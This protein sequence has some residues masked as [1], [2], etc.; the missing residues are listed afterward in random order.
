[1]D[2]LHVYPRMRRG[3]EGPLSLRSSC[4]PTPQSQNNLT[5]IYWPT[6]TPPHWPGFAPPLTNVR[7]CNVDDVLYPVS[8]MT[9]VEQ[10]LFAWDSN[11]HAAVGH[12]HGTHNKA[13]LV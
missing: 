5:A 11:A 2:V 10:L 3:V 1:M 7:L 13:G 9:S 8:R 6:F 4:P 12:H